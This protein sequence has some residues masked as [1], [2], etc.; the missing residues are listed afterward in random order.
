MTAAAD[1]VADAWPA[2]VPP[3]PTMRALVFREFGGPEVLHLET[4]T[5]PQIG[6][7]DVLIRVA[8]VSV[9]RLLDLVARSGRHPYATFTFPHILGAEHAGVVAATG[10]NVVDLEVGDHVATFPVLTD[11][12]CPFVR[13]GYEELSPTAR[14]IGTHLPGADADYIAVPAVNV[15]GVPPDM[16]PADAVAVALAGAVAMN[17]FIRA[18]LRP[19]QRV[20]V[21]AATSALGSTTALLARHLGAHVA[22]TSRDHKKR[23]RLRELGFDAVLDST[24]PSFVEDVRAA[25]DGSGADIVVDN[26]GDPTLWANGMSALAPGGAMVTS[27][28]FLGKTVAVDLQPL[29]T[30]GHRVIGVRSG[31]KAAAARLLTEVHNGFRSI[32]DRTFPL[33]QTVQ[34]HEYVAANSNVGRVALL[35]RAADE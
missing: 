5:T 32:V 11:P 13:A 16:G 10:A 22:V 31:N 14:I 26:L 18:D 15:F 6:P 25:F 2:T 1:A 30:F 7:D 12:A 21:Q 20:L 4:V 23:T 35:T 24:S 33:T 19:R 8:A 3:P 27:G 17:Q 9:G 34:A 29:Y 28:A